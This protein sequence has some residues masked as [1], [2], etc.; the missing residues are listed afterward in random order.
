MIDSIST[1]SPT[2]QNRDVV[3]VQLTFPL[4]GFPNTNILSPFS[5]IPSYD[6]LLI[7]LAASRN[8]S[9]REWAVSVTAEATCDTGDDV[10]A[11]EE[12]LNCLE[13]R[14]GASV[15]AMRGIV[16]GRTSRDIAARWSRWKEMEE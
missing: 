6:G 4:P 15:G 12:L 9:A 16:L 7:N 1:E 3:E 10:D 8:L 2:V 11:V 13:A 14:C 5:S